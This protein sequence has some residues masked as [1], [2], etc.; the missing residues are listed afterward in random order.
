[1]KCL[2]ALSFLVYLT[3]AQEFYFDNNLEGWT[4]L[5]GLWH[6]ANRQMIPNQLPPGMADGFAVLDDG[7]TASDDLFWSGISAPYGGEANV[8]FFSRSDEI[9]GLNSFKLMKSYSSAL[10]IEVFDFGPYINSDN[11][12]FIT[13]NIILDPDPELFSVSS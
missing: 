8:T 11:T 6:W 13:L 1:M 5:N 4:P 10:G 7:I 9:L 12:E 3:C 2:V